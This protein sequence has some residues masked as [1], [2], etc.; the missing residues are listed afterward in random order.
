MTNHHE[1][2]TP[3]RWFG[4]SCSPSCW[5]Q[6]WPYSC[7]SLFACGVT[8]DN[9]PRQALARHPNSFVGDAGRDDFILLVNAQAG[10]PLSG[11]SLKTS[12]RPELYRF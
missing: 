7:L 5:S 10:L 8:N 1:E 2:P 6:R 11:A 9:R 12:T 4:P 3:L